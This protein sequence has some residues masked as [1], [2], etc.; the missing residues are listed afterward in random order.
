MHR[1]SRIWNR[2][3]AIPR[4]FTQNVKKARKVSPL[5][6]PIPS[7]GVNLSRP[8]G[9]YPADARTFLAAQLHA[10]AF[11]SPTRRGIVGRALP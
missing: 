5:A 3:T 10:G 6:G 11:W 9:P 2:A 7:S 8:Q 4:H 1:L